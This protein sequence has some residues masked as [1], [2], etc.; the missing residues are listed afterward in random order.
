MLILNT[1]LVDKINYQ[2]TLEVKQEK[3]F[4]DSEEQNLENIIILN[5]KKYYFEYL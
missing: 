4:T 2:E 3:I 1:N 5:W